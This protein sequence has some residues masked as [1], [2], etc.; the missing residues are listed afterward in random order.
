[1]KVKD[2]NFLFRPHPTCRLRKAEETQGSSREPVT[3][4][5]GQ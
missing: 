5:P 1:M 3:V 2:I 4:H